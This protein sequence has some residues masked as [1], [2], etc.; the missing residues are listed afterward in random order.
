MTVFSIIFTCLIGLLSNISYAEY[1]LEVLAVRII[2]PDEASKRYLVY[3]NP[4]DSEP[5]GI[6]IGT[7]ENDASVRMGVVVQR[8]HTR[9]VSI[10][11]T[12]ILDVS[13]LKF[14]KKRRLI[15]YSPS[16][17]PLR[18]GFF[19]AYRSRLKKNKTTRKG[20]RKK[21]KRLAGFENSLEALYWAPSCGRFMGLVLP[22]DQ[23]SSRV[24]VL[25]AIEEVGFL[26]CS[27]YENKVGTIPDISLEASHNKPS[28]LIT[29]S[30]NALRRFDTRLTVIK[31]GSLKVSQDGAGETKKVSFQYLRRC[32]EAPLGITVQTG[33][34]KILVS[35]ALV[36]FE[37]S[38]CSDSGYSAMWSTH[39]TKILNANALDQ[40]E[41]RSNLDETSKSILVQEP[42]KVRLSEQGKLIKFE[43]IRSCLPAVSTL[44]VERYNRN[45]AAIIRGVDQKKQDCGDPF[46]HVTLS[47]RLLAN[48]LQVSQIAPLELVH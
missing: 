17:E 25:G 12:E 3:K 16:I 21:V 41:L 20:D 4:C 19:D 31:P 18:Y 10:D 6:Y 33:K 24:N 48:A 45:Y 5:F 42:N 8:P 36:S 2:E 47:Q 11:K 13:H 7:D 32:N 38:I 14:G 28:P 1:N 9:C 30:T 22:L 40:I 29:Q 46:S 44:F 43:A 27:S 23:Q 34:S 37:R 39:T 35:M 26:D 15:S